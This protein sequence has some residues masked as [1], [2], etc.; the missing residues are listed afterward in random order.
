[1]GSLLRRCQFQHVWPDGNR[2]AHGL[3]RQVALAAD[4]DVWV[5][6]LPSDLD[7]VFQS[8]LP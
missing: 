4:T 7:V 6:E 3:A 1:M 8:D 2:L 5:E